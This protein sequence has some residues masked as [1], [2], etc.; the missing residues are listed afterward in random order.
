MC[1][2]I[3]VDLPNKWPI[4]KV[5]KGLQPWLKLGSDFDLQ[6]PYGFELTGL[7][8][9]LFYV[10]SDQAWT[11]LQTNVGSLAILSINFGPGDVEWLFVSSSET[12]KLEAGLKADMPSEE[13]NI[14]DNNVS[15]Y[16]LQKDWLDKHNIKCEVHVQK[17]NEVIFIPEGVRYKTF[18]VEHT[19]SARYS[20]LP[21]SSDAILGAINSYK[22]IRDVAYW[23][24]P[25]PLPRV[26]H[27]LILT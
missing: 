24:S 20:L 19:V 13:G 4:K 8:K 27:S 5:V 14:G 10:R 12:I 25:V 2:A 9:L 21:F 18:S 16:H 22:S 26:L 6:R 3:N 1:L 23:P 11:T 17:Q 7:N 15:R